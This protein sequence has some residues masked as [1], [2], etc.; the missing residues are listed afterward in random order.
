MA[1]TGDGVND[2]PAL[3]KADIGKCLEEEMREVLEHDLEMILPISQNMGNVATWQTFKMCDQQII[4]SACASLQ[5][6]QSSLIS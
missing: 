2:S 4:R 1:V 5:S 6:Y 3:K